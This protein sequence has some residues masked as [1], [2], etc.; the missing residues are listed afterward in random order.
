MSGGDGNDQGN[1]GPG[2][3]GGSAGGNGRRCRTARVYPVWWQQQCV[4]WSG[5]KVLWLG[6]TITYCGFCTVCDLFNE[7]G[8]NVYNL[9][10]FTLDNL[11]PND[12]GSERISHN[13]AERFNSVL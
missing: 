10:Q 7:S 6:D 5:K 11:H 13:M 2:H 9:S 3:N 12:A 4:A 8:V 1:T